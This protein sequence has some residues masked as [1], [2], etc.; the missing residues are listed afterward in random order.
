MVLESKLDLEK[1]HATQNEEEDHVP[2]WKLLDG[3]DQQEM[4][5]VVNTLTGRFE[6]HLYLD[7]Q[8]RSSDKYIQIYKICQFIRMG[9]FNF[10]RT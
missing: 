3:V 1:S 5:A 6:F 4:T 2:S 10:D 9:A 8:L 7:S